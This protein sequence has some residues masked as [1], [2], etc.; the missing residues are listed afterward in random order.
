MSKLLQRRAILK[1]AVV[2]VG[3]A[4]FGEAIFACTQS[5]ATGKRGDI[6]PAP[7]PNQNGDDDD[8]TK[9]SEYVPG[10]STPVVVN[11][12][13]NL[14][15]TDYEARVKQLEDE[16]ARLFRPTPFTAESPGTNKDA[17]VPNTTAGG[18]GDGG[19]GGGGDGG[20]GGKSVKVVVNH[21]MGNN[22]LDGGYNDAGK[23]DASDGGDA[24]DAGDAGPTVKPETHY[25]TT[26][27]LRGQYNGQ[28][29]VIGLH[30]FE[31]TDKAPPT[32][33]FKIPDGV[34]SVT[35]YEWCTLHG[36]WSGAPVTV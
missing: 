35:A 7:D 29:T 28:D 5:S 22:L 30:E 26:I 4:A 19:G 11:P 12:P 32:V 1:S 24:G 34:T 2:G 16:Q 13:A 15:N 8:S 33:I 9:S 3:V 6:T 31:E 17:H 18:G 10:E 14:P 20:G 25:I 23:A 27:Y 21:V 36:L